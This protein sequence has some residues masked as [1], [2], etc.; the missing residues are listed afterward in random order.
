MD[1]QKRFA[2][3]SATI[4][5]WTVTQDDLVLGDDDGVVFIPASQAD[6]LFTLAESIRDTERRQAAL[7]HSGTSLRS[8]VGFSDYLAER[9]K[10]PS[11]TFREHLRG[12]GGAI[13]E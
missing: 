10:R 8:Q 2:L 5:E 6:E 9:K 3:I 1:L 7:I 4:G 11:L 13:E 12:V